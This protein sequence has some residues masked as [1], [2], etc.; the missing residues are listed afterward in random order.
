MGKCT[1]SSQGSEPENPPIQPSEVAVRAALEYG[2]EDPLTLCDI[3][4][5]D[6]GQHFVSKRNRLIPCESDGE[7]GP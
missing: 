3:C 4:G 7:E 5:E 6:R 2:I 1:N